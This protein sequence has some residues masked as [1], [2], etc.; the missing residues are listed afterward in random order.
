MHVAASS[1]MLIVLWREDVMSD[2]SSFAL[3][4]VLSRAN[5][6]QT[7]IPEASYTPLGDFYA[8]FLPEA[9][10]CPVKYGYYSGIIAFQ[11]SDRSISRGHFG[12]HHDVSSDHPAFRSRSPF[13]TF[14]RHAAAPLSSSFH[15]GNEALAK[16]LVRRR[17][18]PWHIVK[19]Y[20]KVSKHS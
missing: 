5:I 12:I 15:D 18:M 14:M 17:P 7:S 6:H 11:V 9:L 13:T 16:Y 4:R 10:R 20:C 3:G 8:K 19:T 2:E 1:V